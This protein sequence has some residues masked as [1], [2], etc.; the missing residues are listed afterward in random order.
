LASDRSFL[1]QTLSL[2]GRAPSGKSSAGIGKELKMKH[3]TFVNTILIVIF[4]TSTAFIA[5]AASKDDITKVREATTQFQRTP[6]ARA[7]GYNWVAGYNYCFQ[8]YGVGGMGY[9]YINT[10]LL[11]T[12]VDILHPEA[13]VYAP[14]ANGSIQLGA[15]KYMV[16]VAAWD[17]EHTDPPQLMGQNFHVHKKLSMYVLHVWIWRNNPSGVFEDWNPDVSCPEPIPWKGPMNWR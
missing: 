13:L 5:H 8:S 14:D 7:A 12:T 16:P 9:H 17:A 3:K 2:A 10:E 11:D 6:A 15:V 1:I 4:T